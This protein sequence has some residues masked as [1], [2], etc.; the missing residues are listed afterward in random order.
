MFNQ[1]SSTRGVA[2]ADLV[3]HVVGYVL[4]LRTGAV[5]STVN[6]YHIAQLV[7]PLL[8]EMMWNVY[9]ISSKKS[10]KVKNLCFSVYLSVSV[11]VCP[12]EGVSFISMVYQYGITKD[13]EGNVFRWDSNPAPPLESRGE[14]KPYLL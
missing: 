5:S 2:S 6:S 10:I 14:D 7:C 11:R 3:V 9:T 8:Y 4:Y 1:P 13:D 12:F